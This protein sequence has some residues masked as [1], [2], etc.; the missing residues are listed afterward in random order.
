[1]KNTTIIQDDLVYQLFYKADCSDEIIKDI[2]QSFNLKF[3]FVRCNE[4]SIYSNNILVYMPINSQK[5]F[6]IKY[7]KYSEYKFFG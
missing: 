6:E 4:T 1:M 3:I 5:R 2:L 7:P